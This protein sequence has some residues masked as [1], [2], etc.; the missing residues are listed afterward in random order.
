MLFVRSSSKQSVHKLSNAGTDSGKNTPLSR[1][2]SFNKKRKNSENFSWPQ[3]L[4]GD[5]YLKCTETRKNS[6][7]VVNGSQMSKSSAKVTIKNNMLNIKSSKESAKTNKVNDNEINRC[8]KVPKNLDLSTM[9][10]EV[11]E[12]GDLII[13]VEKSH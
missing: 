11:A 9:T 12:N 5:G 13:R 6:I 4:E 2:K 7:L 3:N 1:N 10:K 8:Y